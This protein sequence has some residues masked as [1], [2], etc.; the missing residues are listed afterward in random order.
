[1]ILTIASGVTSVQTNARVTAV[2]AGSFNI[3]IENNHASS[4]ETGAILMNFAIIKAV[5][6]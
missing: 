1:M 3:T 5:R 4:A 6:G 2:S